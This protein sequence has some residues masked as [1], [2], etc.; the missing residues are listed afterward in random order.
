MWLLAGQ[1]ITE[2]EQWNFYYGAPVYKGLAVMKRSIE[3]YCKSVRA[4]GRRI[5]QC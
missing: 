1:E 3:F 5:V 4:L 2:A